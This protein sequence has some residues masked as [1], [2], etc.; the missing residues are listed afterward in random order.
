MNIFEEHSEIEE[1]VSVSTGFMTTEFIQGD[2]DSTNDNMYDYRDIMDV[3]CDQESP[4]EEDKI[5][6]DIIGKL[7]CNIKGYP[8]IL[9]K[10]RNRNE[11]SRMNK[12]KK[13]SDSINKPNINSNISTELKLNTFHSNISPLQ[14]KK[15]FSEEKF[16]QYLFSIEKFLQNLFSVEKFLQNLISVEKFLQNL[17]SAT[18]EKFF[19]SL[20]SAEKFLQNLCSK[21]RISPPPIPQENKIPQNITEDSILAEDRIPPNLP[22]NINLSALP[23]ESN[24]PK[25]IRKDNRNFSAIKNISL[26]DESFQNMF[27]ENKHD[28]S[29]NNK[30]ILTGSNQDENHSSINDIFKRN[31]IIMNN[32]SIK[33]NYSYDLYFIHQNIELTVFNYQTFIKN[34]NN[35]TKKK[36]L[37]LYN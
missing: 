6:I 4:N 36:N 30:G 20:F 1:N 13:N 9:N 8:Q 34:H 22:E 37:H 18:K 2:E 32:D 7:C 24:S 21:E 27:S 19:Q 35:R 15:L 3:F 31:P 5:E 26:N 14:N 11:K 33:S 17:F 16:L 28:N 25:N 29:Y 12:S 10:K 23:K